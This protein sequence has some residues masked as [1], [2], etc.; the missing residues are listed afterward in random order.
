MS[1]IYLQGREVESSEAYCWD[2]DPCAMEP[3]KDIKKHEEKRAQPRAKRGG[4]NGANLGTVVK[5]VPTPTKSM[6]TSGDMEQAKHS[7]DNRPEYRKVNGGSLNPYWVEWLM[8]WPIGQTDLKPLAMDKF[9][10]W[11]QQHSGF[12][13]RG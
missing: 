13:Q 8:G 9:Q 1:F 7:S 5:M 11:L 12:Y 6:M 2:T 4:G 10:Q 3:E